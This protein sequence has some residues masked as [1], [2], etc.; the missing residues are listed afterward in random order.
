MFLR[1]IRIS[2][3]DYT[4]SKFR[5]T[6]SEQSPP[7]S[8]L[9]IRQ[10]CDWPEHCPSLFRKVKSKF[11]PV[12]RRHMVEWRYSSTVLDL[13]TGWRRVISFK[14][15]PVHLRGKDTRYLTDRI[16]CGPQSR[17]GRCEAQTIF[18]ALPG[19]DPQS[20]SPAPRKSWLYSLQNSVAFSPQANYTDRA[21]AACRRS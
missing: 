18:L 11:V 15:C 19:I 7:L 10:T 8:P 2:I 21:T 17:S 20:S 16:L 14:P 6:I 13:R 9:N 1:N 5:R 12:L 3:Q 4:V